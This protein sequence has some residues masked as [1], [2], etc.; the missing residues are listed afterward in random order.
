V[1]IRLSQHFTGE[2]LVNLTLAWW[3]SMDESAGD[4]FRNSTSRSRFSPVHSASAYTRPNACVA[5]QQCSAP[6]ASRESCPLAPTLTRIAC[7]LMMMTAPALNR[8]GVD[9]Q[10]S[11]A[12]AME[13]HTAVPYGKGAIF[14]DGSLYIHP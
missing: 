13:R 8:G 4:C 12:N 7:Q 9:A 1:N 6:R 14:I 3:Q 5:Y 11:D 10:D 2:E